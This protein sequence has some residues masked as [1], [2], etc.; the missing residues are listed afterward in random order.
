MADFLDALG[1]YAN[2]RIDRATQPFTDPGT[3]MQNRAYGSIGMAPPGETEEERRKRLE[4]EAAERGNTEVGSTTVKNYADGSQEEVVKKQIPAPVESA[5]APVMQPPPSVAPAFAPPVP[6]QPPPSIAPVQQ[7][8]PVAPQMTP[9]VAP[10][11][12]QA[13]PIINDQ[14][15]VLGRETPQQMVTGAQTNAPIQQAP[16][17][18]APIQQAPIQQAPQPQGPIAPPQMMPAA[19]PAATAPAP[20]NPAQVPEPAPVIQPPAPQPDWSQK[21]STAKTPDEVLNLLGD[22]NT[23]KDVRAHAAEQYASLLATDKKTKQAEQ[24]LINAGKGDPKATNEFTR[25]LKKS[26]EEGSYL[27]AIFFA[28]MG[29]T[30]LAKEEQQKLGAG[31]QYQS[32]VGPNG[33]NYN[34]VVNGQGAI[35]KAFTKEGNLVDDNTLAGLSANMMGKGAVTGQTFGKDA[36]GNVISH[37]VLPNGRGVRWKNETTGESLASAPAGY[38]SMGQKSLEQLAAEKG[39]STAAS[40]E[41]KMRKANT[42][43]SLM[44]IP[45]PFTEQQITTA[46]NQATTSAAG[47]QFTNPSIKVISAT[48]PTAQQ[49]GMWDESVRAGREGVTAE[50]NPIARPGTSAHETGNAYDIDNNQL[51]AAGRKELIQKGYYQPIPQRDPNHWEKLEPETTAAASNPTIKNAPPAG[52]APT[53]A[54]KIANY[55]MKPPQSRSA[56]YG[57]LMQEVSR[58]NPGYDETRYATVQDARKKFTTGKQ[59]DTVRSMNVAIDHLDTLNEAG[60]ALRNGNMPLFNK[61]ANTYSQNTGSEIVTDFNGIKSIVGSEVAKAVAGGQMALADREEI[62]KELSAANSPEQLAGVIKKF[63][64]LLGGQLKGLKTQYEEA[65]LKDFDHKLT[66]RTKRVL[67]EGNGNKTSQQSRSNW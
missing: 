29:L 18:Q 26:G 53:M 6:V 23:P 64:Q 27:K 38:H 46:K 33:E 19:A 59:G 39:V 1:Q 40:V 49:K 5:P 15:Q 32:V 65:G 34:A 12:P 54:Q 47:A 57:P 31:T 67:G 2:N 55:E 58:L 44:G 37:T 3:Y 63:Q 28:R 21:L 11:A 48:R 60:Q 43:A 4:R 10:P 36:N 62:R 17:Q 20:V 30:E 51:T 45:A 41:T 25:E 7:Q 42:D 16:I 66:D 22:P 8:G 56:M 13:Q 35:V 61:I 9:A 24:V 52:A 50:G 14:G